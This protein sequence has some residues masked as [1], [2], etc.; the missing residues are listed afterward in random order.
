MNG[1]RE[2]L[3]GNRER[4]QID[5]DPK[6]DADST[7]KNSREGETASRGDN[8]RGDGAD[9]AEDEVWQEECFEVGGHEEV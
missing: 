3:I 8:G 6:G 4:E 5:G 7:E 1:T 2:A 9:D